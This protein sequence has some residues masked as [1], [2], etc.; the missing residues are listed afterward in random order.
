MAII[1]TLFA[2]VRF[3]LALAII[4][5]LG[6]FFRDEISGFLGTRGGENIVMAEPSEE[7]ATNVEET[8]RKLMVGEGASEIRFTETALQS[9]LQYR[10]GAR[11]SPALD[12][13]AIELTDSTLLI[14]GMVD[15]TQLTLDGRLSPENLRR[16]MGDSAKVSGEVMPEIAAPGRAQLNII[17]LQAGVFPVPPFLI[18]TAL[19]AAAGIQS[20][21]SSIVLPIPDNILDVRVEN[22]EI[23]LIRER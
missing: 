13:L 17:S 7:L 9:Y 18:A 1:R 10:T 14:T 3:I 2:G 15:L 6:W 22:E 8:L 5:S 11:F 16:V 20:D 23:V 19:Q 4:A 21:G 12:D